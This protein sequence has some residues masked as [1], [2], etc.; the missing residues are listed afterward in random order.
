MID[1]KIAI[2]I[3]VALLIVSFVL[4]SFVISLCY[5]LAKALK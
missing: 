3:G 1:F 2:A 5:K 4:M